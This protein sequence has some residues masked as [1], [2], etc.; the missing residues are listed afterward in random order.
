[1][2][3]GRRY[4][5]RGCLIVGTLLTVLAIFAVFANRQLLNA[6][7][8]ADTSTAMLENP[9]I[10]S[11]VAAYTVDQVYANVDV[12]GEVSSALPRRLKPLAGPA[13]NGLRELAER[14]MRRVLDR[15]RVQEAW[16]TAN[17]VTAQQFINVAEDKSGAITTQ[18]NAVFLDLRVIVVELVA[19]LGLP[20]SL[21][22]KIP[23]TAGRIKIMSATQVSTLQDATKVL[24]GLGVIL[25][26]LAFG[27]LG[28]AVVLATGNRR[29]TLLFAGID[30][31]VAGIAALVVRNVAGG[32][33][34]DSLAT[35]DSVRPAVEAVWSLGTG[36]LRDI[37]QAVIIT[38][39]PV[40]AAAWLAGP[41]RPATALR[42][43]GA[44]WLRDH[45]GLTYS[46][47]AVLVLLVVVWGPIP[48]TRKVIPVLIMIALVAIGVEALRRQT[49]REFPDR[50][51]ADTR[52]AL[53]TVTAR[54]QR[55]PANARLAQLER[56]AHLHDTGALSDEEYETEKSALLV[57][58]PAE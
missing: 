50:T 31:V 17:R 38:G 57:G 54:A 19:R 10:R 22:D 37:A 41:T 46:V 58:G 2:S 47:A 44:P 56:L 9:A 48:A 23:P 12:A 45:P 26:V 30:L 49:A 28:L 11:Q 13:A 33:V 20:R 42:R 5:V 27:L 4:A 43:A 36:T 34:V 14:R 55:G 21:S 52:A 32:S 39:I 51:A 3:R 15:P 16:K 53:R 8:W 25:P 35:T 6:D 18:G 40:I 1:M 24:K 7:N 29:R